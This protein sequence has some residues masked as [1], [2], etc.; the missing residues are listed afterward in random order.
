MK[1]LTQKELIKKLNKKQRKL[2]KKNQ[3]MLNLLERI[4]K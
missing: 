1:T 3:K 2:S 4:G